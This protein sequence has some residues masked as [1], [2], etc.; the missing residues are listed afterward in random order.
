M[1][2]VRFASLVNLLMDRE[3]TPELILSRCRADLII[4]KVT[5]LLVDEAARQRQLTVFPEVLA[6]LTDGDHCPSVKAAKVVLDV[7]EEHAKLSD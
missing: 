2:K 7:I 6:K 4:P 3:V 5:E 1:V